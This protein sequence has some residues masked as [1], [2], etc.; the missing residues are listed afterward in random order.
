VAALLGFLATAAA[1]IDVTT[2]RRGGRAVPR[3]RRHRVRRAA[4]EDTTQFDGIPVTTVARTL[5]DLA[6]ILDESA[7]E[8]AFEAAEHAELLD[9]R[10]LDLTMARN[11]GRRAHRRLRRRARPRA[12][13]SSCLAAIGSFASPICSF[14][15][16][17]TGSRREFARCWRSSHERKRS[18]AVPVGGGRCVRPQGGSGALPR[19]WSWGAY[20]RA[21]CS[22]STASCAVSVGERP[23]RTPRPS[24]ASFLASA[25]PEEPE[26][27]APA[28]PICLP[29]GAVKPAM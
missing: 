6:E 1:R 15:T 14:G 17:R 5:F 21:A 22:A 11:P 28:W 9:M 12:M 8:R 27:I 25:V 3:I 20:A 13:P 4:P 26:M 2:P 10:A 24:R 16:S 29:G 7:L 19:E 18:R 23:T